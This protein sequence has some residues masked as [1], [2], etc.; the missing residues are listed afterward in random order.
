MGVIFKYDCFTLFSMRWMVVLLVLVLLTGCLVT[1]DAK[2]VVKEKSEEPEDEPKVVLDETIQPVEENIT[3]IV[4]SNETENVSEDISEAKKED[5]IKPLVPNATLSAYEIP[6]FGV[7]LR[8][9]GLDCG[10][11]DPLE[12]DIWCHK[13]CGVPEKNAT[14]SS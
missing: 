10:R 6:E 1:P 5:V 8:T 3:V 4:E 12:C 9:C 14:D 11:M 7:C 13:Y 2:K